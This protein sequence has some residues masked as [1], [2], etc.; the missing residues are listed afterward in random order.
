MDKAVVK[1]L[2]ILEILSN[3]SKPMGVTELAQAA[4]LGKSNVHR[5]LQ[6]LSELS[7]VQTAGNGSY[8]A[9]LKMW[10]LGSHVFSR[11]GVRDIAR[12]FMQA[13]SEVTKETVHL[14]ELN[15]G[16]VLYI[17][18]IESSEPVRA[19]TQLGGRAPAYCTAT[20]KAMLAYN[21]E[22]E[23]ETC[24]QTVNTF[25]AKTITNL[26]R[27]LDEAAQIRKKRY[28]INRGEW[29]ADIV[30]LAA[31]L[32]NAEGIVC[33]AIGIS[34]PA[35]RLDLREMEVLAPRVVGYAEQI[36]ADLGCSE[37][38]WT[39]LDQTPIKNSSTARPKSAST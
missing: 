17:D 19:Y 35:S 20:G 36:S 9:S 18:K 27:F 8:R 39:M 33:G 15:S 16:E 21:S 12:P 11:L 29:R 10:E 25:T 2:R 6:T 14:S 7:Y 1:A 31:P 37:T 5:L 4:D 23:L 3:S 32:V 22:E 24:F 30:G 28:A 34:G 13:L 38:V 26:G